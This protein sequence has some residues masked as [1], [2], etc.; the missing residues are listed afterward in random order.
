MSMQ[1]SRKFVDI[2]ALV[3]EVRDGDTIALPSA[4]NTDFSG[5]S[6]VG[7]RALIRRGVR[8]LNMVLVP[9]GSIQADLLIGSGCV[10]TL[11]SGSVL[12]Y[13]YGRAYRFTAAQK[14]GAIRVKESTCPAI[15]ASLIAGEKGL[16]FM[17]VRGLIGSDILRY[18]EQEGDWRVIDNPF[19]KDDPVVLVP[20]LRPDVT[21]LHVPLADRVG[22]IWIG[23]RG[24]FATLARGAHRTLVT[25]ERYFE[26]NLFEESAMASG[27]VPE[28]YVSALS[29]Q[30]KG[31]WPLH[32]GADYAEDA[33]HLREYARLARTDEG[34]S[35]YLTRYVLG[36]RE[37]A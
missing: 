35:E 32:M 37:A 10:A 31:A 28:M 33:D 13:E 14:S 19:G 36:T 21:L 16:P 22:N 1:I 24:E 20:A 15:H 8:R 6:M 23:R 25:F 4:F 9:A 7:V 27:V 26:G 30:P 18:R 3:S 34:F 12:L 29:H 11:E 5:V 2:E 17:P